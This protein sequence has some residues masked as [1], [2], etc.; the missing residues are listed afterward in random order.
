MHSD[1]AIAVVTGVVGYFLIAGLVQVLKF[2]VFAAKITAETSL[3]LFSFAI[4][5]AYVF[6]AQGVTD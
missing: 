4:Q 3:F 5:R 2:N 6:A 1:S